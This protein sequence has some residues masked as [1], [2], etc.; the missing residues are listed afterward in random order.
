MGDFNGDTVPDVALAGGVGY[1]VFDG[2][3]LMDGTTADAGTGYQDGFVEGG[4]GGNSDLT[5]CR[6]PDLERPRP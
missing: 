1:A 5:T 3:K 6:D 2:K 4:T